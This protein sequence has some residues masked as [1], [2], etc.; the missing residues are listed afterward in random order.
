MSRDLNVFFS[1]GVSRIKM[2]K[3]RFYPRDIKHVNVANIQNES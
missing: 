2:M 1:L 3:I